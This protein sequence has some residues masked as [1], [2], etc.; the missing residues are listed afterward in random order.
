MGDLRSSMATEFR[1]I[2]NDM[3]LTH[4][5]TLSSASSEQQ[6]EWQS[7]SWNDGKLLHAVPK[8]WEFPARVNAKAI[9]NLWF[10]G[11]RDSKIRPYRLLNK[12][13][14]ISTAHRMRHSR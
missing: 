10:F 12:Q 4:T 2:L 6:P 1:S 8:N 5:T 7:W 3:N 9:W 14:D 13:H 11:D